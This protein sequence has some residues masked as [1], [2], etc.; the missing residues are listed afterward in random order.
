MW[1]E[2]LSSDFLCVFM[3]KFLKNVC[4]EID[5][6]RRFVVYHLE[7]FCLFVCLLFICFLVFEGYF[8]WFHTSNRDLSDPY[9]H[10]EAS[11]SDFLMNFHVRNYFP[12]YCERVIVEATDESRFYR[13]LTTTII[14]T[15]RSKQIALSQ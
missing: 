11:A 14:K 15:P 12:L 6:T 8:I 13:P 7:D 3:K 2:G 9:I 1:R 4:F 5:G 10:Y